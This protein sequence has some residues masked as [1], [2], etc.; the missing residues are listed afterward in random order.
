VRLD[1]DEMI[2]DVQSTPD[3]GDTSGTL[4]YLER[5]AT[6][7][8]TLKDGETIVIGGLVR[9]RVTRSETKVPVLGDIPLLGALFRSRADRIEK[10][11]LILILTP[12]IIRDSTDLRRIFERKMQERQE[13]M[14][15]ESRCRCRN[16]RPASARSP[17]PRA[18]ARA[19]PQGRP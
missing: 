9:S 19:C 7:T 10:S 3:K 5:T 16:R 1:V 4:S 18:A 6:T 14:D 17:R 11:N 12:H 13:L 15:H 2:S 8:L